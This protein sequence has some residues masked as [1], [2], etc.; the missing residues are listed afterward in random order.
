MMIIPKLG[1]VFFLYLMRIQFDLPH[2]SWNLLLIAGVLS[3]IIGSL[4]LNS[5]LLIKRF[6][7]YSGI[8][9]VG[10]ML[11]AL[12]TSDL[13]LNLLS[14]SLAYF[15]YAIIYAISSLSLFLIIIRMSTYLGKEIK[16]L[17]QLY[18]M[19]QFNPYLSISFGLT[20]FSLIGVPPLLGFYAKLLIIFSLI[21]T[22]FYIA[23]IV[24][25]FS[26]IACARYLTLVKNVSFGFNEYASMQ[27]GKLPKA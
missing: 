18:G 3:I 1:V 13:S 2:S 23:L 5:Q 27:G 17:S 6:L 15:N 8:A 12:E 7:A 25:T 9:H 11:L 20:V 22:H 21:K 16:Y 19:F 24:I 14:T 10:F 4:G 26:V